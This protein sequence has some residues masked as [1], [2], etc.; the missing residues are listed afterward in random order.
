MCA[1]RRDERAVNAGRLSRDIS[2]GRFSRCIVAT[3]ELAFL[4]L[5][6]VDALVF[7]SARR[8]KENVIWVYIKR[9]KAA[10]ENRTRC[11]VFAQPR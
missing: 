1:G 6:K 9:A 8:Y 10:G 4:M 7:R 2:G 11:Y 3:R 5:Y